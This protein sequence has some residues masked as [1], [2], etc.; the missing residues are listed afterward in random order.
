[1]KMVTEFVAFTRIGFV[2][3]MLNNVATCRNI[4][5]NL[6][7]FATTPPI[8]VMQNAFAGVPAVLVAAGPSLAKNMH[9]L[10]ELLG[11]DE[12]EPPRHQDTKDHG[13]RT[14]GG[15]RRG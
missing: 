6:G 15:K 2:T 13:G 10:K 14:E 4:A 3:L 12:I 1:Q 5:N 11:E 7:R 8:D 9:L